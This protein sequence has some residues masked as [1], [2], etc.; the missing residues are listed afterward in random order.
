MKICSAT[1]ANNSAAKAATT[2]TQEGM[3]VGALTSASENQCLAYDED[4]K[5]CCN[6]VVG[7]PEVMNGKQGRCDNQSDSVKTPEEPT[8]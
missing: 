4:Q 3:T 8:Q 6:S 2:L 5:S 7:P 1:I